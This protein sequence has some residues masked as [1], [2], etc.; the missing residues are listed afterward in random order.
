MAAVSVEY[1]L[2]SGEKFMDWSHFSSQICN[3]VLLY[4]N[5][6]NIML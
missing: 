6:T 2:L 1:F 3:K 4:S 5:P